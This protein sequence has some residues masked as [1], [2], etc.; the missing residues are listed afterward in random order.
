MLVNLEE[1]KKVSRLL[2]VL[3]DPYG[4]DVAI[5][6]A[7]DRYGNGIAAAIK[8]IVA[9]PRSYDWEGDRPLRRPFVETSQPLSAT[10]AI[11]C[12]FC[13]PPAPDLNRIELDFANIK[14]PRQYAPPGTPLADIVKCYGNYSE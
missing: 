9:D 13:R 11:I 1:I 12:G 7:Y 4:L 5:P 14:M 6:Q 8:S 10:A 2:K 3:V